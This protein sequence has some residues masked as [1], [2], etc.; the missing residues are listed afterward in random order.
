LIVTRKSEE[1]TASTWGCAYLAPNTRMQYTAKSFSK[2]LGKT[3]SFVVAEKKNY[4]ELAS[5]EIFPKTR[6]HSSHYADFFESNII[7]S[8]INRLIHGMSYFG[9]IQ[10]GRIQSYVLYG[11]FFI[12][13]IFLCTSFG[14]I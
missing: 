1:K 12:L 8:V 9:I 5:G 3:F 13:L 4:T 14:W 2:T 7:D 11:V 6:T 10:N